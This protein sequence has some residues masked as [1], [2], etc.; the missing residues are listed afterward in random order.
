MA[1]NINSISCDIIDGP[2][3]G[4][5]TGARSWKVDGL[6][7]IAIMKTGLAPGRFEFRCIVFK[8]TM[9]D[10]NTWRVSIEALQNEGSY[11]IVDSSAKSHTNCVIENVT[12]VSPKNVIQAG[13]SKF[14]GTLI[15]SGHFRIT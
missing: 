4:S 15:V 8:S 10:V 6:D 9:A 3:S 12:D 14:I 11:T 2:Y 5:K 1:A 13:A 7:G